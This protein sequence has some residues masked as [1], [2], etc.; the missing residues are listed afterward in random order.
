MATAVPTSLDN[1]H[2][3]RPL[4]V[5]SKFYRNRRKILNDYKANSRINDLL[6]YQERHYIY[7]L[8]VCQYVKHIYLHLVYLFHLSTK[9]L[10]ELDQ[11]QYQ[12]EL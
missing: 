9:I 6:L 2:L 5:D 8:C 1:V 12:V 3:Y 10:M 11:Q 7:V 4:S